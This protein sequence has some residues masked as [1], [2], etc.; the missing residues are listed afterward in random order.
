MSILNL[1][2]SPQTQVNMSSITSI[3]I[4][5][6]EKRFTAEYVANTFNRNGIALVSKVF[7]K[8]YK[9]INKNRLN[10]F[11]H[12]Y[13]HIKSWY[14]TEA[15]YSFIQR[16]RNPNL[17]ARIVHSGD[18]WW[19]VDVSRKPAKFNT[20]KHT[21]VL[22]DKK[23]TELLL[24]LVNTFKN[25][26][27]K[28]IPDQIT[29]QYEMDSELV[30]DFNYKCYYNK[31]LEERDRCDELDR[32]REIEENANKHRFVCYQ[33]GVVKEIYIDDE[34]Y[35]DYLLEQYYRYV[36]EMTDSVPYH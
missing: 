1:L 6:V 36:D 14:E 25:A 16:L 23:K 9:N 13:V 28:D 7:L 3:Y 31:Y 22:I 5:H 10:I 33:D 24:S 2:Y 30:L 4:P 19:A 29:V 32:I 21:S 17:E 26:T 34:D 8:P 20:K 11:N 18:N 35:Q 15:S 12:A 27:Q